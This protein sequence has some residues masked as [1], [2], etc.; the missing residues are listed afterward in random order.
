MNVAADPRD[1]IGHMRV[2]LSRSLWVWRLWLCALWRVGPHRHTEMTVG[3]D[4]QKTSFSFY[5][6][7]RARHVT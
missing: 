4:T 1:T 3:S 7:L 6:E 2:A 5:T